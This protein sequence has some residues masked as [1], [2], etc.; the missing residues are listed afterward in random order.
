MDLEKNKKNAIAFYRAAYE[1]N[2]KIAI[3]KY[4]GQEYLQHNPHVADGTQGFID[5]FERMKKDET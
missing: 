5:Y 1:G 3:E 2:P 4:V